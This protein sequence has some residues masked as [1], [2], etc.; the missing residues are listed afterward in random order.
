M[1]KWRRRKRQR[2]SMREKRRSKTNGKE[3]HILERRKQGMKNLQG[4]GKRTGLRRHFTSST[5]LRKS[6]D[7]TLMF[8]ITARPLLSK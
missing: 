6:N 4:R 8:H 5:R 7:A 1:W 2:V 3:M